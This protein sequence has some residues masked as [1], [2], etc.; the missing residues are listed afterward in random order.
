MDHSLSSLLCQVNHQGEVVAVD[1]DLSVQ[2][3]DSGVSEDE[4]LQVLIEKEIGVGFGREESS[5]LLMSDW[6][7]TARLYAIIWILKVSFH[8]H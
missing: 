2:F 3:E 1:E 5:F 8:Q 4:Y 7:K 6:I